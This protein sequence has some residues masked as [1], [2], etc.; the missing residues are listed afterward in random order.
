MKNHKAYAKLISGLEHEAEELERDTEAGLTAAEKIKRRRAKEEKSAEEFRRQAK[1]AVDAQ[2]AKEKRE[3][4]EAEKREKEKAAEEDR[5]RREAEEA[6][7]LELERKTKKFFSV[8]R[9]WNRK[10]PTGVMYVGG[11]PA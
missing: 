4:E 8:D 1:A 9:K 5:L 11:G 10:S 2:E 7:I 6:A 3:K